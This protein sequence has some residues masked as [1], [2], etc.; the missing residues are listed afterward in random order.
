MI[1]FTVNVDKNL[2]IFREV[3]VWADY[4]KSIRLLFPEY[5][6]ELF[7]RLSIRPE[8]SIAS[9]DEQIPIPEHSLLLVFSS[10]RQIQKKIHTDD[11]Q[12]VWG[13]GNKVN[14]RLKPPTEDP[15]EL[16]RKIAEL[17]KIPSTVMDDKALREKEYIRDVF[18]ITRGQ[19][20]KEESSRRF[21]FDLNSPYNL[22]RISGSIKKLAPPYEYLLLKSSKPQKRT[23]LRS[24]R[25]D[26]QMADELTKTYNLYE[27]LKFC[28]TAKSVLTDNREFYNLLQHLSL[29]GKVLFCSMRTTQNRIIDFIQKI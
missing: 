14:I 4:F 10:N 27:I 2:Q 11:T 24:V 5:Q 8:I 19:R 13:F 28:S 22:L 26:S 15:L 16:C 9:I 17:L 20:K 3:V 25:Y 7:A 18:A 29:G 23:K 12:A 1:Y 21:V 6:K